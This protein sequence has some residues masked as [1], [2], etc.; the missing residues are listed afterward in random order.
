MIAHYTKRKAHSDNEMKTYIPTWKL[1]KRK[2]M[3]AKIHV[4]FVTLCQCILN[5]YYGWRN[6]IF[7]H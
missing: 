6:V 5:N 4:S 7:N 3:T 2:M 1:M